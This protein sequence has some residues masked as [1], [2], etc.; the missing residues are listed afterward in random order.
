M[1]QHV[2]NIVF[3]KDFL[4]MP[5]KYNFL[6]TNLMRA[7]NKFTMAELNKVYGAKYSCIEEVRSTAAILHFASK[8]KP[9]KYT[10]VPGSVEWFDY[11]SSSELNFLL[12][13]PSENAAW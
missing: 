1:D 4:P 7:K 13:Q 12:T 2:F 5:I 3:S 11:Y 6:Y 10:N 8:D 9:W